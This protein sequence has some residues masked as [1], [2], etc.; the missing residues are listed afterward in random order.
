MS[1][2][3]VGDGELVLVRGEGAFVWD[4]RGRRYLDVPA[5]LWYCNVGHGRGE[6]VDAVAEQMRQLEA[7]SNFGPFA[8]R[9]TLELADR[10]SS[11]TPV[12]NPKVF[13]TSGGSDAIET[14]AKLARRY[15][16]VLGR[17]QKRLLISRE[18]AY[19]GLHGVGTSIA[20]IQLNREG[21]GTLV[22]ETLRVARDDAGAFETLVQ[23]AGPEN[24]AAFFCEPV[25]GGG[26]I[27]APT[28][29]YLQAVQ[30]ICRANDI[31]FV[32]DEVITGFGRTGA[33]FASQRFGLEPDILVVAK[34]IT[35]GYLPLGAAIV[36]E[37]VWEPFWNRSPA[38]VFRHGITYSGHAS[39]CAAA[40]ANLDILERERLVERVAG[41]E[42]VLASQFKRLESLAP[43]KAIRAGVGLLAAVQFHSHATAA[44]VIDWCTE[45][46]FI[47]RP[48]GDGAALQIS[49]PFVVSERD[50]ERLRQAIEA[51]IGDVAAA[52]AS[53]SEE[54]RTQAA[55]LAGA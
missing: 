25:I 23:E 30:Q 15:W 36:G 16:D 17:P 2:V 46:G 14:A 11:L 41:L 7:Y 3:G 38:P 32:V 40:L 50:I 42:V 52:D 48:I 29:G 22:A 55:D 10:L 24:I 31:I 39:A 54:G 34:G 37:R 19:H 49:P 27:H 47:M 1:A 35:S 12:D 5:S 28:E 21:Y 26:G 4:A 33:L 18:D 13:F 8:T 45:A 6:I 20:G 44:A 53:G 51:A 9:P 43:V